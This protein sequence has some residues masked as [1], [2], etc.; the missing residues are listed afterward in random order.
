[1]G[2]ILTLAQ[3]AKLPTACAELITV[4]IGDQ[5]FAIDIMSVREVRGWATSTPLP[6]APPYVRG[7]INLRGVILPPGAV[8][9]T[10]PPGGTST[11]SN[12]R[13]SEIVTREQ[14]GRL[15]ARVA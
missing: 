7:M 9:A 10:R 4:R 3:L 8:P 5:P 13:A 1:M 15:A 12:D 6:R 14:D 2:G 11:A